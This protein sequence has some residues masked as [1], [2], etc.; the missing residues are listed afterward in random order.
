MAAVC[1]T[2][3][4]FLFVVCLLF[5]RFSSAQESAEPVTEPAIDSAAELATDP[6]TVA[7]DL[8]T[9]LPGGAPLEE[10]VPSGVV[11]IQA[12]SVPLQSVPQQFLPQSVFAETTGDTGDTLDGD[13][14]F[15]RISPTQQSSSAEMTA[16]ESPWCRFQPGSWIRTRTVS[17]AYQ[18]RQSI[19]SVTENKQTLLEVAFDGY[20]LRQ[21]VSV[22]M[23][24]RTFGKAPEDVKYNFYGL[25]VDDRLTEEILPS[26]NV[27]VGLRV[28]PCFVRRFQRTTPEMT[29]VTTI[30]YSTVF[31]PYIHQSHTDT[32]TNDKAGATLRQA[33][34]TIPL[35]HGGLLIGAELPVWLS[36]TIEKREDSVSLT[37][38]I[39]SILVPGGIQRQVTVETDPNGNVL[40]QSTT[41]LL[42]YFVK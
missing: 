2:A 13:L 11:S 7:Q 8:L 39:H 5:S 29:E 23:G 30:W 21:E 31:P 25:A 36:Q 41:T 28:I 18:H 26:A 20:T 37:R 9:L 10:G 40:Y 38:T 3:I 24:N 32:F 19:Q 6:A 12:D 4:V 34:T 16:K 14:P 33:S 27:Q 17:I 42:D 15:E 35:Q 1:G 22:K